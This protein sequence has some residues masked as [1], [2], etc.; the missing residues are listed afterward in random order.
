MKKRAQTVVVTGGCGAIGVNLLRRLTAI[1]GYDIHV[2]DNLSSGNN[3]LPPEVK[4]SNI[5]ISNN[6]KLDNFFK[7]NKPNIVYHLAAH[8]A[9]QNSVDH[10]R[11]DTMTNVVGLINLLEQQIS[12][13]NLEKVVY[14]SSSCV[15]GNSAIMSEDVKVAPYET[16]YAINKYVGELYCKYYAE[17]HQVPLVCARIFNNFGPGEDPGP[18]RNVIPNFILK[19]LRDEELLITGTGDETRDFTYVDS[20][21]DFLYRLE[22]SKYNCAE[23]FNSGTGVGLSI[24]ALAELIIEI[25]G[26]SSTLKFTEARP[27]DHVKHR[28]AD[29]KKSGKCLRY[30]PKPQ[31]RQEL[32]ETVRW[33]RK[34]VDL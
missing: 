7:T 19:A 18:Y 14:A 3:E 1:G 25:T 23:V 33:I 15:Y 21:V 6:E 27:W 13:N 11:S 34:K 8:F 32:E 5:D 17:I 30:D 20:T 10:P 31:F 2:V 26:S 4:F 29:T 12:N 24:K 9:N 22:S 16:P 28:A